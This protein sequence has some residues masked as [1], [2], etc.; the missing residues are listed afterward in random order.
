[1]SEP[2]EIRTGLR[3]GDGLSP[4]LFNCVLEK[5]MREWNKK[6]QPNIKI[7]R[8]I[9]LNCLAF[10][11]DLA[12]L[13][14]SL[15]E[16]KSQIEELETIAAKV[17]LQISFEKTEIMPNFKSEVKV[18]QMNNNKQIKIVN[19]F[20]YLGEILTWN[21]SE[22]ASIEHRT[23]KMKQAQRI[24]WPTYKKKSLS[25]NAK[26]KHYRSVVKPQATYAS[27][28][29]FRLNTSST[30]DKLQKADRRII[31]TI[32]QRKHRVD[33]QW[34]LLPNEEVY[35]NIESV[36]DT[37]RKRRVSFFGHISRLSETRVIKQLFNY[38]MKNKTKNNWFVEIQE[39]LDELNLTM[40]QV[41]NR[42]EKKILKDK[43]L[44]LKLKTCTRRQY[45][46]TEEERMARSRRMKLFWESKKTPKA[47]SPVGV[48]T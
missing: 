13:A 18:I 19:K 22:K 23:T 48:K 28:T 24:T 16:A 15:E 27:E 26:F 34:R 3:Q 4:I 30:T 11:D 44:R 1:M 10:A 36:T 43:D 41:Q 39:D 17:G 21:S 29:L 35:R 5:I 33:E 40:Q 38:F 9:R 32:I 20:K 42:E 25:I 31:R 12:L 2:F 14:N 6:C 7:G 8:N 45:T 47:K 46:I 37:M